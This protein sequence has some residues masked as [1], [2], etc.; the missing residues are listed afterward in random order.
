[1]NVGHRERKEDLNRGKKG[2]DYCAF[3]PVKIRV[4]MCFDEI[5][6]TNDTNNY[7]TFSQLLHEKKPGDASYAGP[8]IVI[9]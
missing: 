8:S 4:V 2:T 7:I 1:M 9:S 5:C 6:Y 3:M